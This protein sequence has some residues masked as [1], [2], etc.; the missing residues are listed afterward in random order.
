MR[1]FGGVRLEDVIVV[2]AGGC[3][4][5]T[6]CPRTRKEVEAVMRG[7]AWPPAL[8]TE[9]WLRRTW[10]KLDAATGK[11]VRDGAVRVAFG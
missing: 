3:R 9:P 5:L 7:E 11:L 1:G 10:T 4:N 6:Q 2:M 8:D